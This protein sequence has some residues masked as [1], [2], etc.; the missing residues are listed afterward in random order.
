M[1]EPG[2]PEARLREAVKQTS[3]AKEQLEGSGLRAE[4]ENIEIL[5]R[6]VLS[7]LEEQRQTEDVLDDLQEAE[8]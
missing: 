7:M 8:A 3:I 4:V 2:S 5:A 1:T 6:G